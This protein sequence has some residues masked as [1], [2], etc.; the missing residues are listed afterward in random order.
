MY[1]AVPVIAGA[2]LGSVTLPGGTAAAYEI[3]HTSLSYSDPERSGRA[4]PT[5]AYYPADISGEDVPVAT[6]PPDG[7]PAVAFGHGFLIP[8]SDYDFV[9]EGLV[10][11]GFIVLLP[12]TESG[13]LPDHLD[14][15]LD[16]AFVLREL[17]DDSADPGSIFFDAVSQAG[18]VCGHSMGGGASFLAADSDPGVTAIANLAAAETNP[19]AISAAASI[20]AP[21]LIFSGSNDCVTPP[22]SHQTPMYDSLVSDCR[23]RVT[24]T[25]GSHCQFAEY[26]FTCS[27]GE[28]GCPSPTITRTEQ[29]DLT[30]SLLV[31]WLRYALE[32]DQAAWLEFESLLASLPGVENVVDCD[33]TSVD[34]G[35]GHEE[36]SS[37]KL[38]SLAPATPNPFSSGTL[39]RYFLA[40][41]LDVE[42]S[43][44][45]L[46]GRLVRRLHEGPQS[47]GW[48][49]TGWDGR[50]ARGV[51]AA[52]GVYR[53][54]VRT[55]DESTCRSIV[56]VR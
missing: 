45:S 15:G 18:A 17:R 10:P 34:A 28:G 20:T 48:H 12:D 7:F 33:A 52:S 13:L 2:L 29:H 40:E 27:L 6:P 30:V 51:P 21:A 55:G 49:T 25:G 4:V 22:G 26:N 39:V 53:C 23:T 24:L 54:S 8:W 38:L 41:R 32:D 44:Y 42:V 9:W 11:E 36:W 5:E 1:C 31:P 37:R 46:D 14:L 47:A 16:L 43:V 35:G 19:S 50:G 3:G 56:L